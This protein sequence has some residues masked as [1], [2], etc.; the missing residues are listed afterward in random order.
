MMIATY[1]SDLLYRYEC[2]I[3]PGF[4][5]FL[6]QNRSAQIQADT[7][8]F[9]PPSKVISFNRQLQTN[10]GLLAN[11]V[12]SAEKCNYELALRQVRDFGIQVEKKLAV[13]ETVTFKGIGTF[14]NN[15]EGNILFTAIDHQNFSTSAF[16]LASFTSPAIERAAVTNTASTSEPIVLVAKESK[17]PYL[18]YASIAVIALVLGGFGGLHLHKNQIENQNFAARQEAQSLI[19]NRIQEAT[20]IMDNPLPAITIDLIKHTGNYHVVAGAFREE[21]NAE[22]RMQQLHEMGY[23][24]RRITTRY[25]LHQILYGS[26][27]SQEEAVTL[28]REIRHSENKN[29][30]LLIQEIQ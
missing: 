1:I 5:A 17:I 10:D 8:T 4:G 11:Y 23:S 25:G 28:L 3:L 13:G 19:E 22:K 14:S 29:A 30:W 16:G 12:A 26:F 2:V 24:P 27:D 21:E 6:T 9:Y 20:F 18:R 7:H 15:S